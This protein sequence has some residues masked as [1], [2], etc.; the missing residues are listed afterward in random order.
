MLALAVY[1]VAG[2]F[3]CWSCNNDRRWQRATMI[4]AWLPLFGYAL[5]VEGIEWWRGH[6]WHYD[7]EPEESS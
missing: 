3:A 4:V 2:L 7:D 6:G 1:L 5:A